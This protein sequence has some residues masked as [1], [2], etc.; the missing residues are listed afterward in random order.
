V[1]KF[2]HKNTN[3]S[4]TVTKTHALS[5]FLYGS[6]VLVD[7]GRFF[8]FLIPKFR[9]KNTNFSDTVT[10]THALSLSLFLYGSTV[11]VDLGRFFSFLIQHTVN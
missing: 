5:L 7:L 4:D 9:H 8:S 10:K 6:T 3:F 1:S 11:L 2:R